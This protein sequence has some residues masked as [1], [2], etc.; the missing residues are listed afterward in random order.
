MPADDRRQSKLRHS[1]VSNINRRP[2]L[3]GSKLP[4]DFRCGELCGRQL[5][6]NWRCQLC[7]RGV[8][9]IGRVAYLPTRSV[10]TADNAESGYLRAESVHDRIRQWPE[11]RGAAEL[12]TNRGAVAELWRHTNVRSGSVHADHAG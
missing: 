7:C 8:S 6:D 11:L 10:P 2:E 1:R 4:D 5:P 9:D 3:S 12:P